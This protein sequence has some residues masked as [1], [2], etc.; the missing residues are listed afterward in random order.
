M[1]VLCLHAYLR[2]PGNYSGSDPGLTVVNSA[3]KAKSQPRRSERDPGR[4]LGADGDA[5]PDSAACVPAFFTIAPAV[6]GAFRWSGTT[7]L[8]FTPDPKRPLPYATT[9]QVTLPQRRG[10]ER[11]AA[12]R[13]ITFT[14]TTPT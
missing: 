2:T 14:F 11:P 8:I 9:Y 5:R 13:D 1:A 7:I 6:A 10:R 4:V 12:R 3:R